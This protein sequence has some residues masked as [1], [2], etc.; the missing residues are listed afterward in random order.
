[1]NRKYI[2]KNYTQITK[3]DT[4]KKHCHGTN[5]TIFTGGFCYEVIFF[6]SAVIAVKACVLVIG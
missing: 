3:K 5:S 4:H 1:M 6:Y 2:D